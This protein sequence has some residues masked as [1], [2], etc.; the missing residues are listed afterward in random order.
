MPELAPVISAFWPL[1]TLLIGQ[2]G[3]TAGGRFS[4]RKC[5]CINS[6]NEEDAGGA[7]GEFGS[8]EFINNSFGLAPAVRSMTEQA[9]G[10]FNRH[11]S[12]LQPVSV[13]SAAGLTFGGQS[14]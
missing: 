7:E 14:S 9:P 13:F 4:S 3:I 2:D 12:R 8:V 1:R 5:C 6:C 11:F 10:M